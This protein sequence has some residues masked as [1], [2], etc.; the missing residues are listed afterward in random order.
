MLQFIANFKEKGGNAMLALLIAPFY[1]L[2]NIYVYIWLI[3]WMKACSKH[4]HKPVVKAI[5]IIIYSFFATSILTAFFLPSRILKYIANIWF[6]SVL[7]IILTI[8]IVDLIR[9]ILKR[10]VKVDPQKLASRKLFV[11]VGALCIVTIITVSLYGAINARIIRTT[12]YEAT[13]H[14]KVESMD[15]M[16]VVLIAD[17]HLGYNKGYTHMKNMVREINKQD[18]DLVV[19]AGDIFDNSYEAVEKPKETEALL[20]GIKSK[21]GVYACWGN[22]DIEEPILAGFTFDQ[23]GKKEAS[24][25]MYEF[26]ANSNITL[27]QDKG[28][29]IN[30][31]FYLYGRADK[32]RPGRGITTRK[33]PAQITAS[34]DHSKPILIIDHE[35]GELEELEAAG[36]DLDLAGHTHDGQMFPGNLTIKLMWENP[37][38]LIKKGNMTEITT[39][40]VG[41]F[42]PNMRVA[43]KAEIVSV[44]VSFQ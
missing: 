21:Y 44:D 32:H 20:R 38:G 8:A 16:K 22:H 17:L 43:T 15:S 7:Y 40:G 29:L 11:S 9:V 37:Y 31:S 13:I 30:D 33:T 12:N 27:L 42:G 14:K 23:K 35:P 19:L 3:R 10:L 25:K 6:G 26:L 2:L 36:V 41:V 18:A 5:V 1:I 4:F 34:M 24:D 39:S 28:T